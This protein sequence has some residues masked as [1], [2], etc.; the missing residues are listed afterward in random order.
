MA[1]LELRVAAFID[2]RPGNHLLAS[3]LN[4]DP[5]ASF[6]FANRSCSPADNGFFS[7]L[8]CHRVVT[9]FSRHCRQHS[10][11]RLSFSNASNFPG[12]AAFGSFATCCT[13]CRGP[14]GMA[15]PSSCARR[16]CRKQPQV[17]ID[18]TSHSPSVEPVNHV[19]RQ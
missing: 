4:L 13:R 7:V 17:S 2:P 19:K 15:T 5:S 18:A 3:T 12:R 8:Q 16:L 1:E 6:N 9:R 11:F 10:P 14:G